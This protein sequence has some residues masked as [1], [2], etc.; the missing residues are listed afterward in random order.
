MHY[1]KSPIFPSRDGSHICL[2]EDEPNGK[3]IYYSSYL[4][5]AHEVAHA[6][7]YHLHGRTSE[8]TAWKIAYTFLKPK[9]WDEE[10]VNEWYSTYKDR[11]KFYWKANPDGRVE[12]MYSSSNKYPGRIHFKNEK[13]MDQMTLPLGR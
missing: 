4:A 8:F 1:I 13:M 9:Y 7:E 10:Q 11:K 12:R 2:V 5:L 6:I 3:H